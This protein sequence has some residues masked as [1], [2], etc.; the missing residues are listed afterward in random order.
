MARTGTVLS[1]EKVTD[2]GVKFAE[3]KV[4]LG[5]GDVVTAVYMP[6]LGESDWPFPG[7]DAALVQAPGAGNWMC[8]GFNDPT[9][10]QPTSAAGE[11]VIYSRSAPGVIAVKLV[12]KTNGDAVW[13]DT[14]TIKPDG[15]IETDGAVTANL[16]VT[17]MNAV[18]AVA[19]KLSTH[20]HPTAVG[21]TSPPTPGT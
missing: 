15:T 9:L 1:F 11:K 17:A 6:P 21:P 20:L 4:D 8:V 16:E 19:V 14:L 10:E 18:P 3:V 2:G 7:D 5:G 13:N 12:M